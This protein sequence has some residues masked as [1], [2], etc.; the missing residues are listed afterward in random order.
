MGPP[1]AV[2]SNFHLLLVMEPV[3]SDEGVV[4]QFGVMML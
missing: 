1:I 3:H 4:E 2:D